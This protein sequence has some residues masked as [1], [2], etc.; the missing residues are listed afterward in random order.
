[1]MSFLRQ[2]LLVCCLLA[3]AAVVPGPASAR[4]APPPA[5]ITLSAGWQFHPDPADRGGALG[6]PAGGGDGWSAVTVPHVFDPRPL[7]QLFSGT[8]G[9][10]R[11]SVRPPPTPSGYG[12]ALRFE[13]VRRSAQVWLNGRLLAAHNDP[14]TPFDV[15]LAGLR[16]GAANEVVV[17]VDNRK[18]A[19][20]REG[21]W[22]WGGI[23]RPV[24]LLP[25]PP[26]TV[27]DPALLSRVDC[28]APGPCR[29][30]AFVFDAWV[31]NHSPTV[32]QP[33]VRVSAHAPESGDV[34]AVTRRG[35]RLAPGA[36][37][38]VRFAVPVPGA[39]QLWEPGHPRLYRA[40]VS[41]LLGGAE[42]QRQTLSAG[43]HAV[44]VHDGRLYLNGRAIDVRGA[45]IEEDVLGHG[46]ALTDSDMDTIV[47]DLRAVHANITRAQYPLDPR[48]L[49]RLDRAG[50]MVWSQAPIYHRDELLVSEAQR[51]AA[52]AT[53]GQ[54]ILQARPHASVIADSVANELSPDPDHVP[55]TRAYM[56]AGAREARDLDPSVPVALDLLSYPGYP[57]EHTYASFDLLGINNYFGWYPGH[58]DHST[59][60]LEDLAPYLRLMHRRYPQQ[61]MVMTEFGAE[62]NVDGPASQ[63]QTYAFQQQYLR[64]TLQAVASLPF[65]NGAIYWT[66]REFAVKPNWDGG[67]HRRDIPL[68]SIHHKGLIA[69]D[70][71]RKP[72]F[73]TAAA[74]FAATPLF[75]P[76][77]G[78]RASPLGPI[79]DVLL[80]ALTL[81]TVLALAAL[82]VWSFV[83]IRAAAGRRPPPPPPIRVRRGDRAAPDT[84]GV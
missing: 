26:V 68:D 73:A 31:Q 61:A 28:G 33:E 69:Y 24:Q 36:Q 37:E 49:D 29:S 19:E 4:P 79:G 70:G 62:A 23:T 59:A 27:T 45:S 78:P 82:S 25:Q 47:A 67:A 18:G 60:R 14:Y 54:T 44:A 66:L 34:A 11:T 63:K 13:Q 53:L 39:P 48:L 20:P 84:V 58:R 8:V 64:R 52:L 57:P 9:W 21:W 83:G 32:Q 22:N 80:L 56:E 16:A 38:R 17:R 50:I 72:A 40:Q 46:P 35:P 12:W 77:S 5:A 7:P 6:L 65:M 3:W 81:A 55:S 51:T 15:P 10:Y 30:A 76:L 74:L 43:L 41:P 71:T 42:V 2:A 75:R 1:M